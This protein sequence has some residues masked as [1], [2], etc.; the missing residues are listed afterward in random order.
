MISST[1]RPNNVNHV[2]NTLNGMKKPDNVNVFQQMQV[3]QMLK[4]L[5]LEKL[6]VEF[7]AYQKNHILME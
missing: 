1:L 4:I 6:E 7:H 2:T 5:S 3:I